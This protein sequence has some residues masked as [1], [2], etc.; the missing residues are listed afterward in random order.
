MLKS[1]FISLALVLT[2]FATHAEETAP[3][4]FKKQRALYVKQVA[5]SIQTM[6]KLKACYAR[7]ANAGALEKC[8]G[9]AVTA[10]L[11]SPPPVAPT[12]A[13]AADTTLPTQPDPLAP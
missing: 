10:L 12:K 4:D 7:A 5:E 13:Q 3:K 8:A 11:Q 2:S 9:T 1:T 6:T